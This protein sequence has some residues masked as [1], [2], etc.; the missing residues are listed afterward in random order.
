MH[1]M[2]SC[3]ASCHRFWT[4]TR[5]STLPRTNRF[6][7]KSV[8][9]YLACRKLRKQTPPPPPPPSFPP[10]PLQEGKEN[11]RRR[12]VWPAHS[13]KPHLRPRIMLPMRPRKQISPPP[14]PPPPP[15]SF[16]LRRK[17]N[18]MRLQPYT[19][20]PER[21]HQC[22]RSKRPCAASHR[23]MTRLQRTIMPISPKLRR[24]ESYGQRILRRGRQQRGVCQACKDAGMSHKQI[25]H[26]NGIVYTR[27]F[28]CQ[29]PLSYAAP[30]STSMRC[31]ESVEKGMYSNCRQRLSIR[32]HGRGTVAARAARH[33]RPVSCLTRAQHLVIFELRLQGNYREKAASWRA[34]R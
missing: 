11:R 26:G 30:I 9:Q 7:K 3:R 27:R 34:R 6:Q 18:W 25:K 33:L 5:L 16:P 24:A 31:S 2:P 21:R 19:A 17:E 10:R 14:P 4:K 29:R 20:P 8:L 13:K 15:P 28:R 12:R 32:A 23:Q 1:S 22:R